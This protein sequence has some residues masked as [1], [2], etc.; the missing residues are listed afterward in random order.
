MKDKTS[1]KPIFGAESVLHFVSSQ[2]E[3]VETMVEEKQPTEEDLG[4]KDKLRQE[5]RAKAREALEQK[6]RNTENSQMRAMLRSQKEAEQ[7]EREREKRLRKKVNKNVDEE[8]GLELQTNLTKEESTESPG[9]K[10]KKSTQCNKSTANQKL[11]L[12]L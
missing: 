1:S 3:S 11:L 9:T 12:S 7:K 2:L 8:T 5:K 4:L 10:L 6:R